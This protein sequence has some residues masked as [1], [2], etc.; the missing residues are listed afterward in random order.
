M[1]ARRRRAFKKVFIC[2]F[3]AI[4][5]FTNV[6]VICTNVYFDGWMPREPRPQAGRIFPTKSH[7]TTVYI[8][9]V[10][11]KWQN[12]ISYVLAPLEGLG[13]YWFRNY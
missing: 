3:F 1:Y 13:G 4:A 12:F 6:S 11:L 5:V 2:S 7:H 8:T 10:E 9:A